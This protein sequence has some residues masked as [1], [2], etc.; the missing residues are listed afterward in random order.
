VFS[1]NTHA[2]GLALADF[3]LGAVNEFRQSTPFTLDITQKY[4]GLYAQDT[5]RLSPNVTMNYGVRWEPWFPQEHRQGQ[6]YGFDADLFRAGQRSQVYPQA[7]PGFTYPGDEGFPTKAGMERVWLNVQPRVGISWD[8]NGEG[9]TSVRAGYGMNSNFVAGE[10]YFDSAQAPPFGLEQRLVQPGR[11]SLDDPWGVDGRANPYPA[12]LGPDLEFPPYSLLIQVPRDLETTR[13]HSWNVGVQQQIGE[14]MGVSVSYLGNRMTNVWGT[15]A[16]NPGTIPASPPTGPCTLRNPAAPGGTQTYPNCSAAPIDV[17]REITQADPEVG[18]Y[19]G[20]LDWVTD[21]GWQQYHGVL[22]SVQRRAANGIST[23]VNYTIS[24]C[25]GLVTQ[26]GGP[27]NVGTGY[28]QSV[29]LINPPADADERFESD[30]GNCGDW[31][32]HIL[33]LTASVETPQFANTAARLIASGWRLSGIFRVQSGSTMTISTGRTSFNGVQGGTARV[34]QVLDDPYGDKSLNNWFNPAAFAQPTAGTYGDSG[35]NAYFGPSRKV[36]DLSLVR[37]FTFRGTQ[38]I[39]AR[40]EAFNAFN[41]FLWNN[42]QANFSNANFGRIL[43]A[44]DPRIMQFALKYQ[45]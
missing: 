11:Y 15:V 31:R 9:R 3:M 25:E 44:G 17:R 18:Q 13:V 12:A 33:N 2:T 19:I 16:G 28:T 37:A 7:P 8:P 6:I 1:F 4:F 22:L 43:S 38:R 36:V 10:F 26:G 24:A 5:W 20:Y 23:N 29:S 27:L 34:N 41:W 35:R 40:V 30:K 45:F 42:P 32:R 21:A 14:N 39:E